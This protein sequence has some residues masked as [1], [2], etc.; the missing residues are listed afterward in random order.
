MAFVILGLA[1]VTVARAREQIE[2]EREEEEER[3]FLLS[4][5]FSVAINEG[6]TKLDEKNVEKEE[7]VM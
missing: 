5:K 4:P 3:V 1:S 6:P 7:K 2:K